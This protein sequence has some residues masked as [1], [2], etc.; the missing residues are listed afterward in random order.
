MQGDYNPSAMK[1][2]HGKAL[3]PRGIGPPWVE[4][5][6]A[7][8]M[9]GRGPVLYSSIDHREGA[10]EKLTAQLLCHLMQRSGH[11][12]SLPA[13]EMP[14][15]ETDR[16]GRPSLVWQG[17][18]APA[19]SF[20]HAKGRTW[21]CLAWTTGIGIDVAYPEEFLDPYPFARVFRSGELDQATGLCRGEL[22]DRA[23][24]IW[25]IKEA[26]VKASGCGF[27]F[28]D[29]L[30]VRVRVLSPRDG[31]LLSDVYAG[32]SLRAW[33]RQDGQVWMAIALTPSPLLGHK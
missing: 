33:A 32:R 28:F 30:E 20:S 31:G 25:S 21:A 23:A 11:G 1:T 14:T 9:G 16:L 3:S 18:S 15:I 8:P 6:A 19:I 26:A 7:P 5:G 24:L 27:N 29:P 17:A 2:T 10:K 12:I 13:Q 4:I 22:Q